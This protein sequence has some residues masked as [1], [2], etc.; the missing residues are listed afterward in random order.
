MSQFLNLADLSH[1][2]IYDAI[3]FLEVFTWSWIN[4]EMRDK[5]PGRNG[6]KDF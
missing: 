1:E 3:S 6:A 2:K 4:D 5:L